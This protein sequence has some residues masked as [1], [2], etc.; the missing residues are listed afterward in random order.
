M[1]KDVVSQRRDLSEEIVSGELSALYRFF[2][3]MVMKEEEEQD[4]FLGSRV[5]DV[6]L[7]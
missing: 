4:V 6:R 2:E 3:G 5:G 7:A 1:D